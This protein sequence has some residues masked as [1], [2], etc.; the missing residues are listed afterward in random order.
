M[1]A[2]VIFVGVF[3]GMFL[4]RLFLATVVF[5][6][7]L[8][9]G[10][11]CPICDAETLRVQHRVWNALLPRFRTSWCPECGWEGLMQRSAVRSPSRS[12][13]RSPEFSARR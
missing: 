11:E 5:Y 10:R 9:D 12:A 4:A 8:P 3:A 1:A 13:E 7:I 6:W 2:A